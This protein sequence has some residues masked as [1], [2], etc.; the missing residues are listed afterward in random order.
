MDRMSRKKNG[1]GCRA[2]CMTPEKN[3]PGGHRQRQ[4]KKVLWI[5]KGA[6]SI[7]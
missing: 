7:R 3:H 4:R 2:G 6:Y 1:Y 5:N